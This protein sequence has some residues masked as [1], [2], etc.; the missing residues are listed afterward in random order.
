MLRRPL[1]GFLHRTLSSNSVVESVKKRRLDI[2][3]N[4]TS[5]IFEP[6]QASQILWYILRGRFGQLPQSIETAYILSR[7]CP[8]KNEDIALVARCGVAETLGAIKNCD[9]RWVA[10]AKDRF[11]LPERVFRDHIARGD[12]GMLLSILMHMTRQTIRVDP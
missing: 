12:N 7:W 5:V 3:L 2:H 10:L 4:A 11:G 9:D 6:N 8:A 1:N